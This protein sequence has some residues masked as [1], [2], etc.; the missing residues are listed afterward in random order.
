[1]F[2]FPSKDAAPKDASFAAHRGRSWFV[3]FAALLPLL[4]ASCYGHRLPGTGQGGNQGGQG[5]GGQ[6]SG[7]QGNG[8]CNEWVFDT[9][10]AN[11]HVMTATLR[12]ATEIH[13]YLPAANNM[14]GVRQRRYWAQLDPEKP[15]GKG[16][17]IVW[18][19]GGGGDVGMACNDKKEVRFFLDQGYRVWV[20]EYRRGWLASSYDPC[21]ERDP[22]AATAEDLKRMPQAAQLAMEDTKAALK[23]IAGKNGG[24]DLVLYGTSFG[25]ALSLACGPYAEAGFA[26][27]NRIRAA[28]AAYGSLPPD[29]ALNNPMPTVLWHGERDP[30]NGPDVGTLYNLGGP[31]AVSIKGGRA[32]YAELEG[33]APNW[34]FMQPFGHGYGPIDDA[35]AAKTMLDC[36]LGSQW[37]QGSYSVS[38]KGID[39]LN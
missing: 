37:P 23:D 19:H 9:T 2:L 1:M 26:G 34:L 17:D 6:G 21:L 4:L 29:M 31:H 38:R 8:P 14:L 32:I 25:G 22:Y 35:D 20:V 5:N 15:N 24:R 39:P 18:L 12:M 7:G 13:D 28:C 36:V 27:E 30:I 10:R 3:L 11:G 33:Q 16:V